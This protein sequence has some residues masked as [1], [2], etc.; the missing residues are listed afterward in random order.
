[1]VVAGK[2]DWKEP[3]ATPDV[4]K[5][6]AGIA[7]FLN[8]VQVLPKSS[9]AYLMTTCVQLQISLL[10]QQYPIL[11]GTTYASH[12]KLSVRPKESLTDKN[13]LKTLNYIMNMSE[14]MSSKKDIRI[15]ISASITVL[16]SSEN[17]PDI[18][19]SA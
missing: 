19:I 15:F 6:V 3:V 14:V 17:G 5:Y 9:M 18:S 16:M 11:R 8:Q 12:G 1:M 10:A 2:P 7:R 13:L 4:V